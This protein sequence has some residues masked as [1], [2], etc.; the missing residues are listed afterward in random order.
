MQIRKK[1]RR[2]NYNQNINMCF[3]NINLID[4]INGLTMLG[5]LRKNV[6]Q[7]F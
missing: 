4:K 3:A 6:L 1:K 2:K 7:C 5:K